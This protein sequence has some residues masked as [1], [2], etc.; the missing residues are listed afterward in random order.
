[1]R[2]A[3]AVPDCGRAAPVSRTCEPAL[4]PSRDPGAPPRRAKE[5]RLRRAARLLF[6]ARRRSAAGAGKLPALTLRRQPARII[7]AGPLRLVRIAAGREPLSAPHPA[8]DLPP[9]GL[10]QVGLVDAGQPV[11][12]LHTRVDR[13]L[14]SA[15]RVDVGTIGGEAGR[16]PGTLGNGAVA[17]GPGVHVP[18]R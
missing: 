18:R 4:L 16:P 7:A 13:L 11:R 14:S 12:R 6:L 10:L 17:G 15:Q 8:E 2:R 3:P 1:M 9:S 5:E